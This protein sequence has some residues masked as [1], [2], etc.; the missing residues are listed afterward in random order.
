MAIH[1]LGLIMHGVTGRM[2]LNQHLIRSI[3][4]IRADGGVALSNGDR[5][6]PDPIHSARYLHQVYTAAMADYSGRV[7]V[8]VLWDKQRGVIV[9]NES[10]EIIRIFN[11]AFD[12]IVRIG[13]RISASTSARSLNG[14]NCCARESKPRGLFLANSLQNLSP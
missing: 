14:S 13:S 9:N 7:T 4:A 5:V 8:P 1:R 3:A 6:V 2:G 12:G 11:S 10:W